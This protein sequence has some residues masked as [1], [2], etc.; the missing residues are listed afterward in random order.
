MSESK[1]HHYIPKF[2]LKNF[3]NNE[4]KIFI[5]NKKDKLNEV[6]QYIPEKVFAE[7]FL[8]STIDNEGNRDNKLEDAFAKLDTESAKVIND[9]LIKSLDNRIQPDLY[10]EDRRVIDLFFYQIAFRSPQTLE[11]ILTDQV[12]DKLIEHMVEN[13]G[14]GGKK[15]SDSEKARVRSDDTKKRIIQNAHIDARW[16]R[17]TEIL[18]MLNRMT[19]TILPLY[20]NNKSFVVASKPMAYLNKEKLPLIWLPIS[21]KFCIS[22]TNIGKPISV[23]APPPDEYIRKINNLL[24][25]QTTVIGSNSDNLLYSLINPK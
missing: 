13:E 20:K 8:N 14:I 7:K 1:K 18:E 4:G 12:Y 25:N 5:W 9:K 6:R 23:L 11:E 22:Y 16:S 3:L 21:P 24:F 15:I 2:I 10:E 17:N 19:L